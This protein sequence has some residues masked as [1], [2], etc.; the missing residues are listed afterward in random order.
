MN[1]EERKMREVNHAHWEEFYA[2]NRNLQESTFC[3]KI[4]EI[5]DEDSVV[6]DVG[7]GSGRD[8]FSFAQAGFDVFAIDRSREAIQANHQLA[9]EE[10]LKGKLEF[11]RID[12][13]DADALSHYF[14]DIG[15]YAKQQN[16]AIVFYL[17]FL[18][19]AIDQETERV[20]LE[21]IT[22]KAA[23]GTKFVA[24]FRTTEDEEKSKV[25]DD[26]Y[27]R[28]INTDDFLA[29]LQARGFV[30][31]EFYKGTGLSIY[32]EEDPFLARV[33]AEKA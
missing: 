11:K 12:L 13:S 21:A 20:L 9:E 28:F 26:H 19:H 29:D 31:H 25:Y 17:R 10:R 4:R 30:I 1:I 8:S 16:K 22:K 24:E 2:H 23:S 33:V 27:R 15:N 7:C 5:I 3:K 14:N 18:L 6:V 32:K